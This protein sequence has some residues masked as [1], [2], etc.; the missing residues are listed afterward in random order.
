MDGVELTGIQPGGILMLLQHQPAGDDGTPIA[1]HREMERRVVVLHRG[2]EGIHT[3]VGVELLTY[4]THQALFPTL[5]RLHLASGKLPIVL[6]LT[7]AALR[8]EILAVANDHRCHHL[9]ALPHLTA[10]AL[11]GDA[12]EG[13]GLLISELLHTP[14][15]TEADGHE[16]HG[17]EKADLEPVEELAGSTRVAVADAPVHGE[18][19]HVE[20]A[21]QLADVLQLA[22]K[23]LLLLDRIDVDAEV[24]T[25][26]QSALIVVGKETGIPVV[27]V[28]GMEQ[29]HTTGLHHPRH[30]AV[31]AARRRH[32]DERVLPRGTLAQPC[33]GIL[34]PGPAMP[35]DVLGQ[36]IADVVLALPPRE[37]LRREMILMEMT[38]KD[39]HR[40]GRLQ[41]AGQDARRIHPVV[42]HEDALVGLEHETAMEDIGEL[43]E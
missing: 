32:A 8:G 9:D 6:E 40:L 30:A 35:Q 3:D 36:E 28:A 16:V 38:G 17:D 33:V 23:A 19:R 21:G 1:V 22:Q 39:I 14:G 37:D 24:G 43:H 4:L 10:L 42:E 18:H 41:I 29:A 27:Q 25:V 12:P 7:I 5:A 26:H 13:H 15:R 31:V 20:T 11:P 2:E 34:L